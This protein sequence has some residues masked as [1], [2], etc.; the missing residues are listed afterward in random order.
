[1]QFIAFHSLSEFNLLSELA[2]QF[3]RRGT[4]RQANLQCYATLLQK[5]FNLS[6]HL[7]SLIYISKVYTAVF[8]VLSSTPCWISAPWILLYSNKISFVD[9]QPQWEWCRESRHTFSIL[10]IYILNINLFSGTSVWWLFHWIVSYP[11][12]FGT[13]SHVYILPCLRFPE[14]LAS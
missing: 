10:Y 5:L 3:S 4:E 2:N 12:L 11:L 6:L 8:N 1:M 13:Q 14:D 9:F 7:N